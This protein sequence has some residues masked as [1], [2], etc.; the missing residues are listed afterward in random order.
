MAKNSDKNNIEE[1]I[2]EKEELLNLD[3]ETIK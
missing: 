2:I 1:E 3:I